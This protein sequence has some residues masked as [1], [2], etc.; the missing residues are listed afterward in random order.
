[1]DAQ[2]LPTA[3]ESTIPAR[4]A[5]VVRDITRGGLAGVIAGVVVG[6]LGG[7]L[8]MRFAALLDPSA[9]GRR[10]DNGELVGAITV[11]GTLA[12]LIFGG[13]FAGITAG[14]AWVVVSP[15]IPGQ[16][17]RR[18]LLT[19]PIAVALGGFML[20]GANNPD[21]DI[22]SPDWANVAMLLALVALT[23]AA[24]AW[25]DEWLERRLPAASRVPVAIAYGVIVLVGLLFLP[26]VIDAY[27]S[28]DICGCLTPPRQTALAL[29]VVGVTTAASWL[30]R[31]VRGQAENPRVLVVVG[32]AG[33]I[34]V[35]VVGFVHLGRQIGLI[36]AAG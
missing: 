3:P 34:A 22:L 19:M 1:M 31:V 5:T 12:L 4:A 33:L 17:W 7:R 18:W 15:W 20:V 30:I 24:V 8:V 14:V 13:V 21:F 11:N 27:N 2:P 16:G 25:L 36:L 29:A 10:T 26:V 6:G 23:G 32:R 35:V 28:V 9:V